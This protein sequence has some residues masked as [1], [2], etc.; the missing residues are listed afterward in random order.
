MYIVYFTQ[1]KKLFFGVVMMFLFGGIV[2]CLAQTNSNTGIL[3]A[4]TYSQR[5]SEGIYVFQ[6]DRNEVKFDLIQTVEGKDSPSF[7]AV[8]PSERYLDAVY[9]AAGTVAAFRI[10]DKGKLA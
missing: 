1:M 8:H 3:Y 9:E 7:L 10:D 6:F 2:S 5:G 4:G